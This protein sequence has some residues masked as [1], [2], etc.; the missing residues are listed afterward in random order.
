[1]QSVRAAA[2][3][4]IFLVAS[5]L[6]IPWQMSALKF[7]LKRRK[8][9]PNNFNKF[10]CW[11]FDIRVHVIGTPV[12]DRGVLMVAN[13]S[14]WLDI[15]AIAASARVSF[16]AKSEVKTWPFFSTMA[17]LAETVFVER[18][19]R[20]KVGETRDELRERLRAGDAIMLFPEGTSS[21]GNRVLPFK[22]ALMGAA[23]IELGA[24]AGGYARHVPV[25]PVSV[26]HIAVHGIPM[27]RENRPLFAWYGD[28]DLAPH[29]WE[30]LTTGP[31]DI[32]IEFHP[33]LTV[34]SAGG[35]K[36]L[37]AKTEAIVRRGVIRALAGQHE[38]ASV[39]HEDAPQGADL[40]GA[41]A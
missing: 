25:Q 3:L 10:L 30:A 27:G 35:R 1:M 11:L 26:T 14:S 17:R 2:S 28:M 6:M 40:A 20:S 33:P 8:T 39:P 37:A 36:A 41:V 5:L 38:Q 15:L 13:H 21:D 24:D 18:E 34:D 19:R 22:S 31:V 23:E 16:V 32:V 4:F 29:L 9:F 12:Q 7:N